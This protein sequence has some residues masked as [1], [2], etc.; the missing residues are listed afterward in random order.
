MAAICLYLKAHQPYRIKKYRVFD[1]GKDHS[2][3]NGNAST[4]VQN[5]DNLKILKKIVEKSY[6]PT[7]QIL[8]SL[9]KKYP[10]FKI[11][12]SLTGTLLEQLLAHFP[13]V[14]ESIHAMV[15]TGKCEILAET[16]YHSL[17][18]FYSLKEFERQVEKHQR[19]IID[20]LGTKPEVFVNT[21]LAYNNQLGQWADQAGYKGIVTEGWDPVLGWRS[22][23]FVYRPANTKKIKVLLKNFRLSDD[24]A[25][26]FSEKS[27]KEWPLTTEKYAHWVNAINGTGTNINLFMDF[28]TF[29]EHQWEAEGIFDFL[30]ALPGELLKHPDNTFMTTT[31]VIDSFEAV[32]ELDVPQVITWADTERD[33]S[34]WNGNKMQRDALHA[35]YEIEKEVLSCGDEDLIRDWQKLQ[36]SDHFYFMCTKWFNDGDVHKYFSPYESPYQAFIVFMNALTDLKLRLTNQ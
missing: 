22:P 5:P 29:G 16:Y 21:E 20:V 17:S 9:L 6:R 23:N 1:I 34:A 24:I 4:D 11:S 33:L 30:S 14:V 12:L 28:E 25:F 15:R 8:L 18:F 26:R 10:Q 19:L 27:W 32:G 2:Y 3:F 7:N 35:I 13:D 31:E 36:T